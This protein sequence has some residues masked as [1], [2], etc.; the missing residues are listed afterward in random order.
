[1]KEELGGFEYWMSPGLTESVKVARSVHLLPR[2]DEYVVAYK[3]RETLIE[4][5]F[6]A[7]KI[8]GY[9]VLFNPKIVVDGVV[10]GTWRR[11]FVKDEVEIEL[12]LF[13]RMSKRQLESIAIAADRYGRFQGRKTVIRDA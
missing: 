4:P 12:N 7:R 3:N 8:G 5:R 11:T 10:L 9:P 1:V 2:L 13:E 6:A